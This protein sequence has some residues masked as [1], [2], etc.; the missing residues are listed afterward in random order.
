LSADR[1]HFSPRRCTMA[2]ALR[3][4]AAFLTIIPAAVVWTAALGP[5]CRGDDDD[6]DPRIVPL[7]ASVDGR[8]YAEWTAA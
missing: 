6:G 3:L 2:P 8:N 4:R 5:P 7:G 1:I